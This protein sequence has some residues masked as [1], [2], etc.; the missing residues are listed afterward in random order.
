MVVLR[1]GALVPSLNKLN[2]GFI[3]LGADEISE[4]LKKVEVKTQKKILR[5]S[6]R[7]ALKPVQEAAKANAP[8]RSGELKKSITVRALPRSRVRFGVQVIAREPGFENWYAKWQ[9][10][11]TK[12]GIK[13][14][15]YFTKAYANKGEVA[16]KTAQQEI[17]KGIMDA[18]D[19][20]GR[21][22]G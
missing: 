17:L 14:K 8:V 19:E 13:P 4:S 22:N 5:K 3:I 10:Y 6:M 21:K 16:S 9:E 15:R 11:G 1:W 7:K 2:E 12:T 20:E 18:V